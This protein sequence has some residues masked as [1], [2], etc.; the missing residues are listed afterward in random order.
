MTVLM[1][2]YNGQEFVRKSLESV[3]NQTYGDFEFLII[4]DASTDETVSLIKAYDDPRIRLENNAKNLGLASTLNR[5]LDM[6]DT[7]FVTRMDSD[8]ICHPRR[9]E[10]Q[11]SFME[12]HPTCGISGTW[13]RSF[14]LPGQRATLR[15][16]ELP[17]E[18]RVCQFFGSPVAHPTIILRKALLDRH[19]L[20]YDPLFSRTEDFDLCVRASEFFDIRNMPRVAFYYRRHLQSVTVRN[21][22]E[23]LGQVRKIVARQLERIG[24]A[25]SDTE[26]DLHCRPCLGRGAQTPDELIA[27]EEWFHK[28]DRILR[29]SGRFTPAALD[30]GVGRQWFLFCRNSACLGTS[31]L[32]AFLRSKNKHIS[33]ATLKERGLFQA[34]VFYH[35]VRSASKRARSSKPGSPSAQ[36]LVSVVM[37]MRNAEAFL[38]DSVGSILTQTYRNLEFVILDD[39]SSDGSRNFVQSLKDHRIRLIKN[40]KQMGVA[41][42]LNRGFSEARGKYVARMDADDISLPDRLARQVTYLENQSGIAAV[43]TRVHYFG[44]PWGMLDLRPCT[45]SVCAAFLIFATPIVHP[46]VMIRRELLNG[47]GL[48]YRSVFSRS[49]DYDLWVRLVEFG[50]L[51]NLPE[52]L[53][54]YRLHPQS[55]TSQHQETMAIQHRQIVLRA[56]KNRKISLSEVDLDLLCRIIRGE[57]S[58]ALSALTEAV[59]LLKR[60]VREEPETPVAMRHAAAVAW[61]RYCANNGQFGL[62]SWR[63]FCEARLDSDVPAAAF[64]RQRLWVSC[65]W[66]ECKGVVKAA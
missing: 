61:L 59:D 11:V 16:P 44:G 43:G 19:Q 21:E 64:Y 48:T 51:A 65:L 50:G 47:N 58:E 31:A 49:E 13:A 57:R 30:K 53:L 8:D 39:D 42:T 35:T 4:N 40:E 62:R 34:A 15:Y 36:P 22:T 1:A 3:L 25:P 54:R 38:S 29:K 5:G 45:S 23:M 33:I 6:I 55:V 32:R 46:T 27:A 9:F 28:L 52:V 18:A 63:A 17:D 12:E 14:G 66:H 56:L 24:L 60:I 26:L 37:P 20:R 10:W 2:V 41:E 7:E